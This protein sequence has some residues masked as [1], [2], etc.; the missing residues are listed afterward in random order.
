[1]KQYQ[2][3]YIYPILIKHY[4]Y[5]F[6]NVKFYEI[7]SGHVYI[8]YAHINIYI[9]R[10]SMFWLTHHPLDKMADISQMIFLQAFFSKWKV[11][12]FD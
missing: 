11:L 10:L 4:I 3:M 2:D 5:L 9:L 8:S 12:Y 1:M 7:V 6:C